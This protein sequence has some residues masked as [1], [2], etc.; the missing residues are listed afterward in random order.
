MLNH[1]IR[2]TLPVTLVSLGLLTVAVRAHAEL[3]GS[4]MPMPNGATVGTIAPP[5]SAASSAAAASYTVKQTTLW[6]G[7][8]V[9][10]YIGPDGKVFGIAWSGPRM[11]D[12]ATLLGSYLPQVTN[13]IETQRAQRG[14]GR[15]PAT[16]DQSSGLVL[17]SGGHMGFFSGQA[18]LPQA[19]PA[20]VAGSNIQ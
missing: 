18:Y 5:A 14:G 2:A 10:E 4:P 17:H 1:F 9:R 7:T 12:L 13:A 11:P 16:V 19:L 20:G 3:G 8:V 15:G 6:S